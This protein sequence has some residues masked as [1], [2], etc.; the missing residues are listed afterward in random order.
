[1]SDP[2]AG[3]Y[4]M[5]GFL[6]SSTNSSKLEIKNNTFSSVTAGTLFNGAVSSGFSSLVCIQNCQDVTVI[7]N[8]FKRCKGLFAGAIFIYGSNPQNIFQDLVFRGNSY[9]VPEGNLLDLLEAHPQIISNNLIVYFTNNT[10]LGNDIT[11]VGEANNTDINNTCSSSAAPHIL[12]P[13]PTADFEACPED[14]E[15]AEEEKEDAVPVWEE[16]DDTAAR[17]HVGS[18]TLLAMFALVLALLLRVD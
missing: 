2:K 10:D 14:E 7:N 3:F 1:M 11:F 5:T 17:V 15:A 13:T 18:V 9:M 6:I 4:F 12:N 8:T 16:E